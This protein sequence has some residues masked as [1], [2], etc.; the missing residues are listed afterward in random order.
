MTEFERNT[1]L[2]QRMVPRNSFNEW[3][4]GHASHYLSPQLD[5][6]PRLG[7]RLI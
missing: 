3:F 2:V 4:G 7:C 6:K 5:E 1:V